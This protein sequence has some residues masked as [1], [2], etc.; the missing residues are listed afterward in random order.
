MQRLT[1][2]HSYVPSQFPSIWALSRFSCIIQCVPAHLCIETMHV[3]AHIGGLHVYARVPNLACFCMCLLSSKA[4]QVG[5]CVGSYLEMSVHLHSVSC[6]ESWACLR[7][8][9]VC[10]LQVPRELCVCCPRAEGVTVTVTVTDNL[11]KFGVTEKPPPF[12]LS[13]RPCSRAPPTWSVSLME[14]QS[15]FCMW[16]RS[17][18]VGDTEGER[19]GFSVTR[20]SQ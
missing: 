13:R 8:L 19:R 5:G 3:H 18:Q 6:V 4:E 7:V 12:P 11:F 16:G 10:R 17:E 20:V 15:W 2:F 9:R 1:F 14:I